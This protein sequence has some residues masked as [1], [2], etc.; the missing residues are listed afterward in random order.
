M[1]LKSTKDI[2]DYLKKEYVGDERIKGMQ[3]LN[4]VRKFELKRMKESEPVKEYTNKFHEIANRVRLLGSEFTNSR[5]VEKIFVI[6]LEIYEATITALE[7]TK[8]L[9]RII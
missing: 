6:V 4:L 1:S 2:W 7:S 5:I 9:L 3:I 8:D